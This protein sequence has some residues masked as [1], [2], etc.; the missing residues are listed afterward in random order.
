MGDISVEKRE[1]EVGHLGLGG[2]LALEKRLRRGMV[3][4]RVSS[5][6]AVTVPAYFLGE[7]R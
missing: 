5:K 2:R 7:K 6:V 1:A 4:Y 3:W